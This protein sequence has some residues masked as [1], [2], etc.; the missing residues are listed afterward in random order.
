MPLIARSEVPDR[1]RGVGRVDDERVV[2]VRDNGRLETAERG[3]P[4]LGEE[5]DLA[6]PVELVPAEVQQHDH[7]GR[8]RI[9]RV[10]EV[11]LVDLEDR[12]WRRPAP[13]RTSAATRPA[14]MFAPARDVATAPAVATAS[15]SIL[16]VVVLPFV[17]V[18]TKRDCWPALT[19]AA[20]QPAVD[21]PARRARRSSTPTRVGAGAETVEIARSSLRRAMR[22]PRIR[23]HAS[24]A[25]ATRSRKRT[26]RIHDVL[27]GGRRHRRGRPGRSGRVQAS[28]QMNS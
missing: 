13:E 26:H 3:A 15:A 17:P 2:G 16:V 20:E 19:E 28:Y 10:G 12:P 4:P 6:H 27:P 21:R 5:A 18:D 8:E 23:D 24:L 1:R 7:P 25:D 9:D 14:V 11:S 22:R